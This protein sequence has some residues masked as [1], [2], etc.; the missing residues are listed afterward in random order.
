METG[1]FD[2][3]RP[4]FGIGADLKHSVGVAWRVWVLDVI[5]HGIY[6]VTCYPAT[7]LISVIAH[8][9][10]REAREIVGL[11]CE[12]WTG[13]AGLGAYHRVG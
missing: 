12:M 5:G 6:T 9:E 11:Q 13:C 4:F 3:W 1:V 8:T 10:S 7:T 2:L